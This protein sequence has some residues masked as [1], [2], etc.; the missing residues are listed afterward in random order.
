MMRALAKLPDLQRGSVL[1]APRARRCQSVVV[2][3]AA[4]KE[5]KDTI[6]GLVFKPMEE[7]R[8]FCAAR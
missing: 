1:P 6:T 8:L 7:V 2:P 3:R 5:K 4:A